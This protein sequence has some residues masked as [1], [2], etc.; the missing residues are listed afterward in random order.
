MAPLR[1][2]VVETTATRGE[3]VLYRL[4]RP[5]EITCVR[6][7][8]HSTTRWIAVRGD[9]WTQLWCKSCFLAMPS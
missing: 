6:C 5:T 7:A 1:D 4:D 8:A 9:E 3:L 2:R